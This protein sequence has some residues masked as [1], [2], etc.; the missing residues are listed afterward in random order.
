MNERLLRVLI[1]E[2]NP[3]DAELA[4]L[5]LSRAGYAPVITRVQTA[6]AMAAALATG[7]WDLILCDYTMPQ[8]TGLK[9]LELL[10]AADKDI[11]FILISGSAG[12]DIAVAAMKAGAQDYFVK[13]RLALLVPA[14][15]RELQEA[16]RRATARAQL[17]QLHRNEK[18]A[19]LGT[20]LAGVAHELN[21]PLTVIMHQA[22]LLQRLLK[23]DPRQ[24]RADMIGEAVKRCSRIIQNFLAVARQD[25][26]QRV[27]VSINDVV[28]RA[29]ELI[30]Y[31][32]RADN[33]DV[34]LAL[35]QPL[36]SVSGDP[37]ELHQVIINLIG[38]AQYALRSR[39][40]P[41]TLVIRSGV[42]SD[43]GQVTLH[44]Q[45]NAGGIP[46]EIR[47]RIFDPFFTTKPVGQG[48]GIGLALCHGIVCAHDGTIRVESETG[49]GT[50]FII[51]L[52][53][54]PVAVSFD[55]GIPVTSTP[56]PALR[57][58]VVDDDADV[59]AALA[60]MLSAEGHD[61]D[62]ALSSSDALDLLEKRAFDVVVADVHM[63]EVDGPAFYRKAVA[64]F[65]LLSDSFVFI[66]G[67]AFDPDTDEFLSRIGAV[68]L[69]KPCSF[70]EIDDAL[71]QVVSARSER[72]RRSNVG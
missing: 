37:Q 18:L 50:T 57:I 26:P 8:F 24:V 45:D 61:V 67:D 7:D 47:S 16:E 17:E 38:N 23:D 54:A 59:G 25:P 13:G 41:R 12:E 29:I 43:T 66:T 55:E 27:P 42:E 53:V 32:L 9:A 34:S 58:L 35:Q 11:P 56:V 30:D 22:S 62:V 5:E 10:K 48:T 14:I 60:D 36:P 69:P 72:D 15:Q 40:G 3:A 46:P 21:N 20:L 28:R 63:P 52:P 49:T 51:T 33:I 65:P 64:R 44:V 71:H 2:D 68:R 1:V 39:S 4:E 31:G 70:E 19:A 6:A